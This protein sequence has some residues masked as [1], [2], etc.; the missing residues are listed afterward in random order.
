[1]DSIELVVARFWEKVDR[2]GP[3]ECWPWLGA[4]DQSGYGSFG[5][6]GSRYRAHRVALMTRE[7]PPSPQH[8]AC[9][10]CDNPNC[11]NPAHLW[12]GTNAENQADKGRKGRTASPFPVKLT[13]DDVRAIRASPLSQ[14]KLGKIYGVHWTNISAIKRGLSWKNV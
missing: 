5:A 8:C 11:V 14:L 6:K 12:W 1:M 2:R 3:D 7:D 10:T 13:A 4:T 9:H